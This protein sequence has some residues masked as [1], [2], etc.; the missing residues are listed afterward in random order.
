[1]F[2]TQSKKVQNSKNAKKC[3]RDFEIFG[4]FIR[5]K[6]EFGISGDFLKNNKKTHQNPPIR[7]G[8]TTHPGIKKWSI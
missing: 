5:N 3:A 4:I 6:K 7:G 2:K 1:M 8:I